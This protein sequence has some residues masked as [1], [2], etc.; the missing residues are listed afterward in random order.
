MG[1]GRA[2]VDGGLTSEKGPLP[3]QPEVAQERCL[4]DP[5][6]PQAASQ[7]NMPSWGECTCFT[8]QSS[9]LWAHKWDEFNSQSNTPP[10]LHHCRFILAQPHR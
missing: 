1:V 7:G 6:C 5:D 9:G 4:D 10:V 8:T 2:E 3:S